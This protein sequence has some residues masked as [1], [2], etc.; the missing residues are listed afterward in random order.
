MT[1]SSQPK[2]SAEQKAA[3]LDALKIV[4]DNGEI[5]PGNPLVKPEGQ[6]PK[7]D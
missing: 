1:Q 7:E 6:V 4:H 3:V 5:R 2:L